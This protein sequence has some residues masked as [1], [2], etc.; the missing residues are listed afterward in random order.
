MV[1]MKT[2]KVWDALLSHPNEWMHILNICDSADLTSKQVVR[3]LSGFQTPFLQREH[4]ED[5]TYA[6]IYATDEELHE[7]QKKIV[8]E[9]HNID[10]D[11]IHAIDAVLLPFGWVS[12]TDIAYDT[13]L[14]P[15]KISAA[16]T[17]M[18]NVI[19]KTIGNTNVYAKVE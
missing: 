3:I 8:R 7:L 13:G 6:C 9:F 11:F 16:L 10:D 14:K 4:R 18:D 5:G 1:N 19:H 2:Y 12:V 15:L 17:T